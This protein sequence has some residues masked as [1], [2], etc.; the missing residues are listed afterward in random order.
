MGEIFPVRVLRIFQ[1][2]KPLPLQ[3][4]A[5][6]TYEIPLLI[7][8]N[9]ILSSVYVQAL[10]PGATVDARYV[11]TTTGDRTGELVELDEHPLLAVAG[12]TSK[13][14]VTRIHNKPRLVVNV[15]GGNAT[16]G[17]YLTPVSSFA[18]DLDAALHFE[19]EAVRLDRDKGIPITTYDE[20]NGVWRF[21]RSNENG[22]LEV[23]VPGVLQVTQAL[24]NTRLY[25]ATVAL[26]AGSEI[27]H[28]NYT[29]PAGKTFT[30]LGG[31][32]FSDG[33]AQWRVYL[34]TAILTTRWNQYDIPQIPLSLSAPLE[35][36]AGD[37]LEVWA[38]NRSPELNTNNVETWIYGSEV[39]A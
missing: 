3:E 28:I 18:S 8:S 19:E 21:L 13:L 31:Q 6:G 35:L 38:K 9:S 14:T 1:T 12:V 33:W 34:N 20:T 4:R 11:E 30:L 22:R 15:A 24:I 26:A 2:D 37:V 27:Q 10:D 16:F 5:V 7:E 32:G 23:D 39:D 17:V 25:A 29:V 36:T